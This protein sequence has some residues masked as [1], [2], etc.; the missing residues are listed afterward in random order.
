MKKIQLSKH[1]VPLLID[2]DGTLF[3]TS[4]LK[5]EI[6]LLLSRA[7]FDQK[8]IIFAYKKACEKKLFSYRSLLKH[9]PQNKTLNTSKIINLLKKIHY[10]NKNKL[11]SDTI[12]FL[13]NIDRKKYQIILLTLGNPEFQKFK[14]KNTK[15]AKYFDA[16]LF[17]KIEKWEYLPK[18]LSKKQNFVMIDDREDTIAK[19][20]EKFPNAKALC[21]VREVSDTDD[22]TKTKKAEGIKKIKALTKEAVFGNN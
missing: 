12:I 20:G 16:L 8:Q 15:I 4:A 10:N 6:F 13:K 1:K 3:N 2:F 17:T 18:Y 5:K 9:L 22:P 7:G 11:Y 14:V 19:I 21:I